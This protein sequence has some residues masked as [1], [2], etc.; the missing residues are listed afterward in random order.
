MKLKSGPL[1]LGRF[2]VSLDP[3]SIGARA[4]RDTRLRKAGRPRSHSRSDLA[5]RARLIWRLEST[6]PRGFGYANIRL[7]PAVGQGSDIRT[8]TSSLPPAF[9]GRL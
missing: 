9:E 2:L 4:E 5:M 6:C 1:E 3:S 7:S 8:I